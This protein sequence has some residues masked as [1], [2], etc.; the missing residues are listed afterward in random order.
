MTE[1]VDIE[2]E[3]EPPPR[4]G[5]LK[6]LENLV[7]YPLRRYVPYC[8]PGAGDESQG[9]LFQAQPDEYA[10][11]IVFP[12]FWIFGFWGVVGPLFA[13]VRHIGW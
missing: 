11:L 10:F 8:R 4:R 2:K 9:L 13:A 7:P 6:N 1:E 5:S 3:S 12:L